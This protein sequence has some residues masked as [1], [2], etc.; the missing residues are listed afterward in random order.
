[1][2]KKKYKVELL[3]PVGS[4]ESLIAAI[5]NGADAV[6]F[7]IGHINMRSASTANFDLNDLKK[8][9]QIC[10]KNKIK[11]YLTVNTI[12]YDEDLDLMK[13][14]IAAA[15]KNKVSAVIVSDMAAIQYAYNI[16]MPLHISTQLSISNIEALKFYSQYA[17]QVVLAR[18]LTLPMI[19]NISQ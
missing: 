4:Y 15:K 2:P 11:S 13:K 14:I 5:K 7:G 10:L 8:I 1:M 18:E 3:A 17:Q 9:S 19:K 16:K 12:L 6:Y